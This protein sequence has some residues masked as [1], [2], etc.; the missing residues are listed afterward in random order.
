MYTSLFPVRL[1]LLLFW[2]TLLAGFAAAAQGQPKRVALLVGNQAYAVGALRYPVQDVAHMREALLAIGFQPQDV[3]VL[4]N[5]D[6]KQLRRALQQFGQRAR[7]AE[8]ALLYYSGHATQA[9]GHNWLIPIGAEVR[10]EAD[11][12]LEAVSA[13]AALTQLHEAAPRLSVV[14]LD[15]CRDNPVAV[16]KSGTK[17]LGRMDAGAGTLIAF[18]TAPNEVA[19]DTG[20]Y[21]KVLAAQLR[22]PGL[23]LLDVFRNT[24]AEVRKATNGRQV[25]RVSEVS[26]EERVYLAGAPTANMGTAV[27]EAATSPGL[28]SGPGPVPGVSLDDLQRE[29]QRR[30]EW[31]QWQTAMK[32]DFDKISAFAGSADLQLKAWERF[33][34]G[35]AQDNPGTRDDD[36]LRRLA[37]EAVQRL[38]SALKPAVAPAREKVWL[39]LDVHFDFDKVSLEPESQA[40]LSE[41]VAKIKALQLEVVMVV[42]HTDTS[43]PSDTV[44]RTVSMRRAE[45]VKAYLVAAG[46]AASRVVTAGKGRSQPVA[47][48][49]SAEGRA[50][51][52]RVEIEVVGTRA[53]AQ[54]R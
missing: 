9:R 16:T 10:S 54:S 35:W 23:E 51:N 36:E 53:V 41:L 30:R 25:P 2:A 20:V 48:N 3:A 7:G 37:G 21:A 12:E 8:V 32:A 50:Q 19:A 1:I 31:V 40:R 39:A 44:A 17:G 43:E 13:Q 33:L 46:V 4:T 6:Q 29:D 11:Y 45:A 49:Q 24:T 28:G 34:A 15:A 47:D 14:V 26:L 38:Q 18:A 52:R 27:P 42:G 5:A 22:R